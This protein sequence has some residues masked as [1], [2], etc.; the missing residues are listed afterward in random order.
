MLTRPSNTGAD[1]SVLE[2]AT[3][4]VQ[5]YI[6]F[7]LASVSCGCFARTIP[8]S[9]FEITDQCQGWVGARSCHSKCPVPDSHICSAQI[10]TNVQYSPVPQT[11]PRTEYSPGQGTCGVPAAWASLQLASQVSG[12]PT[13]RPGWG[14]DG[15]S[16]AQGRGSWGLDSLIYG[17]PD[18]PAMGGGSPASP[19]PGLGIPAQHQGPTG[20]RP[21]V[22]DPSEPQPSVWDPAGGGGSG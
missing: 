9:N 14:S 15:A 20:A 7:I 18:A 5:P 8:F 21:G 19:S 11:R 10:E 1:D 3:S 2:R 12:S 6:V 22:L 13:G 4:C 16:T 17:S